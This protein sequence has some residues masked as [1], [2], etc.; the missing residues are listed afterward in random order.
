LLHGHIH[1]LDTLSYLLGDPEIESVRGE[2]LPRDLA[3]DG[4]RLDKDPSAIYHVLF[5]D[6][7]EAW[8][9]PAGHWEFE[10]VGTDGAIRSRNNGV[11]WELRKVGPQAGKRRFVEAAEFPEVE[12]KS[13]V[14]ACLEDLVTAHESGGTTLGNV[15]V[16]HRITAACFAMA[17]SHRRGGRWVRPTDVDREMYIFHV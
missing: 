16:T 11:G 5:A 17:E 12:P 6:G 8:T 15:E 9:V 2:L 7:V 14:V 13:A 3:F 1:S 4:S 10:V